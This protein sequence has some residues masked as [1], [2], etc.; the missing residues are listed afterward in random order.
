MF[1]LG[2]ATDPEGDPLSKKFRCTPPPDITHQK[3][4][5]TNHGA[6]AVPTGTTG[7][8]GNGGETYRDHIG[9]VGVGGR[10]A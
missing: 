5:A 6:A 4:G 7:G 8:N 3:E 1:A 2:T 9:D 10:T